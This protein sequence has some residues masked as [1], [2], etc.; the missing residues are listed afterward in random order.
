MSPLSSV[1]IVWDIET[2]F[3][4][5]NTTLSCT[6]LGGPN[7][8]YTWLYNEEV[9]GFGPA[10][11]L[12]NISADNGG[13]YTCIAANNAGNDSAVTDLYIHP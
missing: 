5:D 3:L 4:G 12:T 7:N 9:V 10:L 2:Y 6:S 13:A 8:S 1:S 11:K